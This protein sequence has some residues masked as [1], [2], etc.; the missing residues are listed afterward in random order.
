ML[1]LLLLFLPGIRHLG[2]WIVPDQIL[3]L[4]QELGRYLVR[5][6]LRLL[7]VIVDIVEEVEAES[8]HA[9]LPHHGLVQDPGEDV[10]DDG[11][12]VVHRP[13]HR[14]QLVH[15]ALVDLR[16]FRVTN[17]FSKQNTN[18]LSKWRV[19]QIFFVSKTQIFLAHIGIR[20]LRPIASA[21]G[22]PADEA[23][24]PLHPGGVA[25]DGGVEWNHECLVTSHSAQLR[26]GKYFGST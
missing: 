15:L 12:G 18:I 1:P 11:G 5:L 16:M 8:A 21:D 4:V 10:A 14:H 20:H 7:Q 3:L 2:L 26:S 17:I 25:E 22:H 19:T 24:L 9:L 13:L 6:L 23:H